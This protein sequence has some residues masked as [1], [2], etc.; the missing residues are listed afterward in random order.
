MTKFSNEAVDAMWKMA[1]A[2]AQAEGEP[3]EGQFRCQNCLNIFK[4]EPAFN[5]S[6]F[7]FCAGCKDEAQQVADVI[8][9]E[10]KKNE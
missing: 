7:T 5:W 3:E 9:D 8:V 1:R 2:K 6:G 4:G 10:A